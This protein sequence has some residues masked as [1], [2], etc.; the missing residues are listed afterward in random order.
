MKVDQKALRTG[1][2][3]REM[4]R[5]AG[6]VP[7]PLALFVFLFTLCAVVFDYTTITYEDYTPRLLLLHAGILF[8]EYFLLLA[9]MHRWGLMRKPNWRGF[10][11]YALQLLVKYIAI[12]FGTA[13]LILPGI[14]LA[15]RWLPSYA[16]IFG[17]GLNTF[18]ALDR[19]W[20]ATAPYFFGL[21]GAATVPIG[22]YG[23][24]SL[25]SAAPDYVPSLYDDPAY[26][27]VLSL[28]NVLFNAAFA[29]WT[30]L[31]IAV[32]SLLEGIEQAHDTVLP[33]E[34]A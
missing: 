31:G 23:L 26:I 10:G 16:Y 9:V 2:I 21:L 28:S 29:L 24:G 11:E 19:G 14:F 13:L 34:A 4:F 1:V 5:L 12:M 22:V 25:V 17:K 18:P 7:G 20:D 33:D 27:L 15:V 30:L 8:G 6:G 32:Y 3:L